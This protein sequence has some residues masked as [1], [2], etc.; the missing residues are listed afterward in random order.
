MRNLPLLRSQA[1]DA[2]GLRRRNLVAGGLA[3]AMSAILPAKARDEEAKYGSVGAEEGDR[4]AAASKW[5]VPTIV[6]LAYIEEPPFY[7][8]AADGNVKGSDIELAE[9][10]LRAVGVTTIKYQRTTF[11]ELLPGVE[12]GR[13]DMNVPIFITPEREKRVVFSRPVWALGDGFLLPAGNPKMLTSYQSLAAQGDA[14]L[15]AVGGTVQISAARSEGVSDRQLVVFKDQPEAIA[16]LHTGKIDAFVGTDVG[17][18]ALAEA[19]PRLVAIAHE[20]G[21][22]G[23]VLVGGFSFSK[24]NRNLLEAV[25][26]QLRKYLGSA[27]HRSRMATYGLV[28]AE[29]D[30]VL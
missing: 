23:K 10:V 17:N 20:R 8:T 12:E 5:K 26:G 2:E 25:N 22:D 6:R 30:G 11:A 7:W 18:R 29:I 28:Q 1:L 13:W 19:D 4:S 27:D 24:S 15:G 3:L 14:L 16:A 21:K 9:V